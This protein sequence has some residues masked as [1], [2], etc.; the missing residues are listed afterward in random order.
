MSWIDDLLNGAEKVVRS[1]LRTLCVF[2]GHDFR[3]LIVGGWVV[4]R[5]KLCGKEERIYKT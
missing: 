1:P 3:R 2:E 4:R 5:C